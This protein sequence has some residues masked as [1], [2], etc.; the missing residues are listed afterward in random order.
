MKYTLQEGSFSLYQSDWLDNSMNIL[1]D[2]AN[3]ISVVISR[4][5]IPADSDFEQEFHRQWDTLRPQMGQLKQ[6]PFERVSVGENHQTRGVEVTSEYQRNGQ[7]LFQHQLAVQAIDK[8]YMLV[9][10]YSALRP[11]NDEDAQ[12]WQNLKD[13]LALVPVQD[14]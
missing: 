12:R 1:R 5:P 14:V 11:F 9:F 7:Q 6:S 13:S 2:D 10:T 4:G 3:G 8:P